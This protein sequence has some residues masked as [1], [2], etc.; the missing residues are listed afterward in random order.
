MDK[1]LGKFVAIHP[2]TNGTRYLGRTEF[3]LV[4]KETKK[5]IIGKEV[6]G[7]TQERTIQKD[8]I[9]G[10]IP[11]RDVVEKRQQA[12]QIDNEYTT[13]RLKLFTEYLTKMLAIAQTKKKED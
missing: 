3:L 11:A 4:V 1:Y 9:I 7:S 2:R 8:S 6:D 13:K 10:I 12:R 5:Q